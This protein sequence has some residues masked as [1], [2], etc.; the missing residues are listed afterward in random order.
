MRRYQPTAK[1][2]VMLDEICRADGWVDRKSLMKRHHVSESGLSVLV[3][4]FKAMGLV[5]SRGKIHLGGYSG[6]EQMLQDYNQGREPWKSEQREAGWCR[7]R[8]EVREMVEEGEEPIS[9]PEKIVMVLSD[10]E[11]HNYKEMGEALDMRGCAV[12]TYI[13]KMNAAKSKKYPRIVVDTDVYP[14]EFYIDKRDLR[15]IR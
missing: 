11:R 12:Y 13:S 10:G 15:D 6:A 5:V 9:I 14:R 1:T 8:E 7:R 4:R 2:W 3:R